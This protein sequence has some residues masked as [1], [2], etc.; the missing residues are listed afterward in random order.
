M[1]MTMRDAFERGTDTFNA[2]DLDG[3][4]QVLA[5]D[6]AF[7]APGG[8]RGVGKAA[9]LEFFGGWHAAFPDAH[10]E[11][12]DVHFID[13]IAVEVGTFSGTHNGFLHA[14]LGD[15]PPTGRAVSV[16]YIHVLRFRDGLHVS[17]NLVFDRLLMLE[18]LGLA[19]VPFPV[20]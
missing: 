1:T 12:H 7:V 14:P 10:V 5:D 6:V 8:M 2:H 13:D 17:F 15:V 11:V 9:C 19:P 20:A 18:Q 3:F 16:D 4:A